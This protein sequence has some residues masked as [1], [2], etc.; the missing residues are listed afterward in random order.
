M[1]RVV[2]LLAI[3]SASASVV[4]PA[5]ASTPTVGAANRALVRKVQ[6]RFPG[7]TEEREVSARCRRLTV[8]GHPQFSCLY[9][10][11]RPMSLEE[12]IA[13][14]EE[15]CETTSECRWAYSGLAQVY[16]HGTRLTVELLGP[17]H[18]GG[19]FAP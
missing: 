5:Q 18:V 6:Q 17:L 7:K 14:G 13:E 1:K 10:I 11:A 8:H 9:G 16:I 19:K 2:V 12:G 3:L 15:G 4:A